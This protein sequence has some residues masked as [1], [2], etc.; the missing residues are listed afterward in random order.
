M[1][2][3]SAD[4]A[5]AGPAVTVAA[6]T[7]TATAVTVTVAAAIAATAATTVAPAATLGPCSCCCVCWQVRLGAGGDQYNPGEGAVEG[8]KVL[9]VMGSACLLLHIVDK[10]SAVHGGCAVEGGT[11]RQQL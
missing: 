9:V 4:P 5:V 7:V 2:G 3:E 10:E 11:R 8:L 1:L 6:V